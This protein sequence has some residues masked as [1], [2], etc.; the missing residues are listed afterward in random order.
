MA[1]KSWKMLITIVMLVSA[2]T[3]CDVLQPPVSR[4]E[5]EKRANQSENAIVIGI[6]DSSTA[7]SLFQKGVNL[8]VNEINQRGGVLNRKIQTIVADDKGDMDEGRRIAKQ[9]A[10]N[11]DLIAVIGH[12]YDKVAIPV[13][14]IYEEHG[15]LLLSPGASDPSLT[16]F[17]KDFTFRN[18]PNGV[19]VGRQ[20]AQF[21]HEKGFKR[22]VVFYLRE[23]TYQRLTNNFKEQAGSLGITIPVTRSFFE[24]QIDFRSVL[25]D[26]KKNE[27]FDA[28]FIAGRVP[29]AGY[30][31]K[32]ARGM[33][34]EMPIIGTDGLDSPQLWTV[35]GRAAEETIVMT[36]FDPAQP[37]RATREFVKQF[38]ATYGIEPDTWAAQGY[39]A[40]QVLAYAMEQSGSTVPIVLSNTLRFLERWA[41]VTGAYAFTPKGDITGKAIFFKQARNGS[42]EFLAREAETAIPVDPQYVIEDITLRIPLSAEPETIDPGLASTTT[43]TEVIEQLFLGLTSLDPKTYQAVPALAE[44][45]TVNAEG[46]VY[47]FSLRKGVTWTDGKPVTAHDV[48]WTIQRNINP[49]LKAPSANMLYVLKNGA[50]INQGKLADVTA[51]GV[52]AIDDLTVEF[53]LESPAP[54]F[55]TMLNYAVFRPLPRQVLDQ[56]PEIW[57]DPGHIQT[58]GAYKLARW[59]KGR[60]LILRR[61]PTYYDSLHVAIPEVRYYIVPIASVALAMYQQRQLDVI[62]GTYTNIPRD[63]TTRIKTDPLLRQEYRNEPAFCTVAYGFNTKRPPVDNPL[64]R[65][66]IAAAIDRR[67]LIEL[68]TRGGE[69]P[70]TTFTRPPIFGAVDPGENVGIRFNPGRAAKWLAE[71]GYPDGKDFPDITI[72]YNTTTPTAYST[73]A[74]PLQSFLNH[75]LHITAKLQPVSFKDF[76]QLREQPNT[77]HMFR[78]SWCADYPD[79]NNF[80]NQMFHPT[81]SPNWIGWTN[82]EFADLMD[83]AAQITD[84][85]QRKALYKRAEQI[86]CEDEAAVV[87]LYYEV[88]PILVHPRVKGWYYMA[89]GGQ[90]ICDWSL[91]K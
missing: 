56:Y 66:A 3:A 68:S 28:I 20:I 70:A 71:A 21:V 33:G 38:K 2:L 77:P 5:R 80:L 19:E 86:L 36:V 8:A 29:V 76:R 53:T 50:A 1:M 12:V 85:N 15:I 62:G 32:Q 63:E 51:I 34:L 55:P 75:Y 4:E 31:I 58:N 18:I 73:T 46:T 23:D 49:A 7:P 10:K 16:L 48:V 88:A 69:E 27:T 83:R 54:Y 61:S 90:H 45:W 87:P 13:S 74:H 37:T 39:D 35:A 57:T 81:K 67:L 14:I 44:K 43:A 84:P 60:M 72:L 82:Q 64:V 78:L 79:A 26:L 24:K 59:E 22:V 52:Q 9:F 30:L 17:G 11:P 42:F 47:Q 6:V 25:A 65:K 89:I 40:V 91:Q 41:G